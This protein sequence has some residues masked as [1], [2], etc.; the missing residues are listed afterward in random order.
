MTGPTTP[1]PG[2]PTQPMKDAWLVDGAMTVRQAAAFSGLSRRTLFRLMRDGR[3]PFAKVGRT[4]KGKR[5]IP[6]KCLTQFLS[7]KT[8][9]LAPPHTPMPTTPPRGP[10]RPG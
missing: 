9:L 3:L 5:L 8:V 1:P 4:A 10:T 6:R 2:R 7:F